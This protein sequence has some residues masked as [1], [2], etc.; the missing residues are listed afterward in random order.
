MNDKRIFTNDIKLYRINI[1]KF[2]INGYYN[3]FNFKK[4][5]NVPR[6]I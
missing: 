5:V 6:D 3:N 4:K 1:N 2:G